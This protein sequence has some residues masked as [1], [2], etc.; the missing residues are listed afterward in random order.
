VATSFK[1]AERRTMMGYVPTLEVGV[2][3]LILLAGWRYVWARDWEWTARL[4]P[5][6]KIADINRRIDE[7]LERFGT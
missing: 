4:Q 2:F 3:I 1:R 7:K 6:Q 5:E